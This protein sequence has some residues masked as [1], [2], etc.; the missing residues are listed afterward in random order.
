MELDEIRHAISDT[1]QQLLGLLA[2][3]RQL[4]LAVADAKL[5]QNKP[6]RDQKREQ[7]LLVS[8]ISQGKPLGLDAQYVTRLYH[9]IIEDSV[10]Q[11]QAKIQ[12]QLNGTNQ[13]AVRVAF[14]GGQGSYSYWA[15]QKYFTRRA[16]RMEAAEKPAEELRNDGASQ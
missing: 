7:E 8:L 4:A 13:P 3:R 5:A 2:K 12:G 1:D 15:T 11:Q 16:E 10:L 14:L 9:V 6:I